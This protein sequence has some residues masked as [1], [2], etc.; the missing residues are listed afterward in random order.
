[1]TPPQIKK[2]YGIAKLYSDVFGGNAEELLSKMKI[3][4]KYCL[5]LHYTIKKSLDLRLDMNLITK[6][7]IV[8]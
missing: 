8:G 4:P 1:M 3:N 2:L 7:S 6:N 5:I